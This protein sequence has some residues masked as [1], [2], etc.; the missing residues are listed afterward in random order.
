LL[1][2]TQIKE[3]SLNSEDTIKTAMKLLD[4]SEFGF[5]VVKDKKNKLLGTV[6]DGDI[7]RGI[8]KG[9]NINNSIT[10]CMNKNPKVLKIKDIDKFD[11]VLLKL[12]A[13]NKFIPVVNTKNNI[14]Y[15]FLEQKQTISRTALLMAGGY[16]K[17][18]GIK[19]KNTP[20]PLIKIGTKTILE[21]ILNKLEKFKYNEIY[22]S[23]HYLHKKI[24]NYIKKRKSKS[25][26]HIIYEKDPLGTAGSISF[27]K[28]LNF[29]YLTVINAD[30]VF[31]V[32]LSSLNNYHLEKKS[33][34]TL[35]VAKYQYKVPYGVV[36]F[37]KQ[38]HLKSI[39]EKPFKEQ[40]VLSGIYCIN[41]HLCDLVEEK[42]TNM[43]D[44]IYMAKKL[45]KKISIFPIYEYWNDIGEP[46]TL[47][48]EILR[49][50]KNNL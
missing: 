35:T 19:T 2:I 21:Q 31:D 17:R 47:Q 7:R 4:K 44:L 34:M 13:H 48:N 20:K 28:S 3:V 36:D 14:Q 40:L 32:N 26:I 50:K 27:L 45:G 39:E 1:K 29:D 46:K 43:T 30:I 16:G 49:T 38:F 24:E 15:I 12:K 22:I 41:K 23:T 9:I 25:N 11:E 10:K 8:L 33:D 18:L 6:T 37:D 42:F 5:F